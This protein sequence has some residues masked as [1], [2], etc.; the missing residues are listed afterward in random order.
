MTL[1]KGSSWIRTRT[2]KHL[3]KPREFLISFGP[4]P[5]NKNHILSTDPKISS[6][7]GDHGDLLDDFVWQFAGRSKPGNW[8]DAGDFGQRASRAKDSNNLKSFLEFSN[9]NL[10]NV[11]TK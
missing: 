9:I 10:L 8:S 2:N 4:K 11:Y 7:G 5:P 3:P 1:D 6:P